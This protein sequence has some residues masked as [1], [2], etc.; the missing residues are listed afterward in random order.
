VELCH[1]NEEARCF[2]VFLVFQRLTAWERVQLETDDLTNIRQLA[3]RADR[4]FAL[5]G[6][7]QAGT[8]GA[9]DSA[10]EKEDSVVINAVQAGGQRGG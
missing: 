6:H 3:T 8:V 1:D 7:M 9:V 4:L 5:H 10:E 2:F